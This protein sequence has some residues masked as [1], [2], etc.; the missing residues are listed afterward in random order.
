MNTSLKTA[1]AAFADLLNALDDAR[2]DVTE[3]G[4]EHIDIIVAHV[5]RA[6]RSFDATF[7][8]ES[9]SPAERQAAHLATFG[10]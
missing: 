10:R 6:V 2:A 1:R 9:L 7:G 8:Q 4:E 5:E 3:R